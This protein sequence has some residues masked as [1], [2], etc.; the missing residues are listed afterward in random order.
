M[1]LK[2]PNVAELSLK[3]AQNERKLGKSKEEKLFAILRLAKGFN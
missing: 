2:A 3:L 1:K